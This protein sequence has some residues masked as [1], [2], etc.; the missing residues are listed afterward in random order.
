VILN[1][2]CILKTNLKENL[3]S[4][5]LII[6]LYHL[7]NLI[8]LLSSGISANDFQ[9][10]LH[11]SKRNSSLRLMKIKLYST[12]KQDLDACTHNYDQL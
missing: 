2:F 4:F 10:L 12:L 6:L 11:S 3:H 8:I 9:P 1:Y 7:F 5:N